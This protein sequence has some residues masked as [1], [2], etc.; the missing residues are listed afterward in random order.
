MP[1]AGE[2]LEARF[3]DLARA[4]AQTAVQKGVLTYAEAHGE[5]EYARTS[6]DT[7]GLVVVAGVLRAMEL[8]KLAALEPDV[9]TA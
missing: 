6:D 5:Y 1:A 2:M 3:W 8:Q 9:Q 4:V 7:S